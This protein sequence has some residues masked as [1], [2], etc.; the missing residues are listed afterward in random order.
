MTT[1]LK[2]GIYTIFAPT[3]KAFNNI[4]SSV[5]NNPVQLAAVVKTHIVEGTIFETDLLDGR[6]FDSLAGA[7]LTIVNDGGDIF[8]NTAAVDTTQ[9]ITTRG[10]NIFQIN[11]VLGLPISASKEKASSAGEAAAIFGGIVGSIVLVI[12]GVMLVARR[13]GLKNTTSFGKK[14]KLHTAYEN[15]MFRDRE[16]EEGNFHSSGNNN[17]NNKVHPLSNTNHNQFNDDEEVGYTSYP[18]ASDA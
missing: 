17:N 13:G 1:L 6:T 5:S 14:E 12:A 11:G 8:I 16:A 4:P 9:M 10:G 18:A 2:A 7:T 3:N 15:P